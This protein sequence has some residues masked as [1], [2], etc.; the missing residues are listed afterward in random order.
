MYPLK[1]YNSILQFMQIQ[2]INLMN[3]L[4]INHKILNVNWLKHLPFLIKH[5]NFLINSLNILLQIILHI[6]FIFI[7]LIF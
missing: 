1:H 2:N 5:L 3:I 6:S 7:N 4:L